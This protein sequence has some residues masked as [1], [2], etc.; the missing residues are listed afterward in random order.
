MSAAPRTPSAWAVA[1]LAACAGSAVATN[2]ISQGTRFNSAGVLDLAERSQRIDNGRAVPVDALAAADAEA[3]FAAPAISEDDLQLKFS[4]DEFGC[5]KPS[6]GC[7]V[8]HE[9]ELLGAAGGTVKRDGKRLTVTPVHGEPTE[10][11]DWKIATTRTADGDE[12]THWYLGRLPGSGYARV[13]VQFGHDAPGNFL[14]NPQNG[15]VAFVHNGADL[16]APSPDGKLLVTWNSLNAPLSLRVAALDADGPRLVLQC[17]AAEGET[18][19]TPVSKGW[20]GAAQFDLVV[21]IGAPSKAMA[22]V[23]A[24]LRQDDGRWT[25]AASDTARAAR[26]G[27]GCTQP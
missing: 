10:F 26:I 14:I 22:R 16:V 21:E 12:A 24:R 7:S 9:R 11:I 5:T 19:L 18:R 25:L 6:Q 20:S 2:R 8:A 4:D 27:F 23:G 17:A 3:I 13:E 15:K 1:V